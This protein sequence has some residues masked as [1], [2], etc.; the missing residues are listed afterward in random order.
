M[1]EELKDG[2]PPGTIVA[3]NDSGWMTVEI[4][5]IWFDHFVHHIKPTAQ[6]SALLILDGHGSHINN[7]KVIKRV[8]RTHVTLLCLPPHTSH[9]LQPL[10]GGKL[11]CEAY[12]KGCTSGNAKNAFKKAGF[13]PFDRNSFTDLDFAPA[14]VSEKDESVPN[15]AE[16]ISCMDANTAQPTPGTSRDVQSHPIPRTDATVDAIAN[17]SFEISAIDIRP[18]PKTTTSIK[19]TNRHKGK[20]AILTGSPYRNEL[21][22]QISK[23]MKK[24]KTR[25]KKKE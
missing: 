2:A 10:E 17:L 15:V 20:T 12:L 5:S 23:E 18:L 24:R 8:R 21:Q 6:D 4:F 14:E 1:E 7:S 19:K 22:E 11:F 25:N 9:K 3:C 16:H 13:V